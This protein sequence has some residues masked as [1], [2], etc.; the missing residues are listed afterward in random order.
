MSE[1]EH[2]PHE[3]IKTVLDGVVIIRKK[4]KVIKKLANT[5]IKGTTR[6][7]QRCPNDQAVEYKG[8]IS[9]NI[10]ETAAEDIPYLCQDA[11]IA[12]EKSKIASRNK[13]I[14]PLSLK[15][16][17]EEVRVVSKRWKKA[18]FRDGI[19][20][21]LIEKVTLSHEN[22]EIQFGSFRI[23]L[24]TDNPMGDIIISSIDE[25]VSYQGHVHPH[26]DNSVLC[27]GDGIDLL[28]EALSRGRI[29]DYFGIVESILRTYNDDSA[30]T[31]LG[32]W[33]ESDEDTFY[34]ESCE[35]NRPNDMSQYCN[36][37]E[38]EGC[39]NCLEGSSCS[40]CGE[41]K[42]DKCLVRCNEC[43]NSTCQEC[44]YSCVGC[45]DSLCLECLKKCLCGN[46]VCEKCKISCENCDN[47]LC[48]TCT[49]SHCHDCN[50]E[51]LCCECLENCD[52]CGVS[53]CSSCGDSHQCLLTKTTK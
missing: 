39:F 8:I 23:D 12:L 35:T 13:V 34:C 2:T 53:T 36:Y 41:W 11:I 3:N 10:H 22:T 4:L 14:P 16:I 42:C 17:M 49:G 5:L 26:V 24:N 7:T 45:G 25:I 31:K 48:S 30:Y 29:E 20:S 9:D 44:C 40:D 27:E 51:N 21:V 47:I 15:N 50:E 28:R 18:E 38:R 19:L 32:E 52:D 43:S 1:F 37:C 33:Y 6:R 46:V